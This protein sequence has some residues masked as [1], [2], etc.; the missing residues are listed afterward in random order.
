MSRASG[1]KGTGRAPEPQ[2]GSFDK[3][4]PGGI[5]HVDANPNALATVAEPPRKEQLAEFRGMMAHGVA[6]GTGEHYQREMQAHARHP[7]QPE[8]DDLPPEVTPV[9][10]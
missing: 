8:F 3:G 7:Y 2:Y 5:R 4:I 10:V 9:P 6:P 1:R